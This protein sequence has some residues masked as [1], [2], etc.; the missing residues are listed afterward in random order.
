MLDVGTAEEHYAPLIPNRSFDEIRKSDPN[1]HRYLLGDQH[2]GIPLGEIRVGAQLTPPRQ[3]LAGAPPAHFPTQAFGFNAMQSPALGGLAAGWGASAPPLSDADMAGWPIA[4]AELQSHYEAV[5]QRIG[6]SGATNDALEPFHRGIE[7]LQP[8]PP[9]DANA[10][11]LL[12]AYAPQREAFRAAGFF[13]GA[14]R[15]AMCTQALPGRGATALHDMDF[16]SDAD[17]AVYRPR[18]TIDELRKHSNFKYEAGVVVRTF[19]NAEDGSVRVSGRKLPEGR[20]IEFAAERLILAAGTLNTS[21]IVLSS[22]QKWNLSIPILSNPYVYFPCLMWKRIGAPTGEARHS[23]TQ[24]AAYFVSDNAFGRA[25]QAQ[26]YSY[27]SLLNFKLVKESPGGVSASTQIMR[28]L[29]PYFIIVGIHHEDRPTEA[30]RLQVLKADQHALEQLTIHYARS[31][32]EASEQRRAEHQMMGCFRR[33]GAV[34]IK[35]IDP[36]PGSSIHYGGSLPMSNDEKQLTT[37]P[38]GSLRGARNVF[39]ADGSVLPHLPAKGL[40]FTLMAN[41]DRIGCGVLKGL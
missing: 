8:A 14:P 29:H 38:D 19:A 31:A 34:P 30:K 5:A 25:A 26:V 36:G 17:R 4:R 22:Y 37:R 11:A 16:W 20:T 40:T 9:Q 21:R 24:L 13:L 18:Y 39:I 35:R 12:A 1:Q 28:L 41:A 3:Y 6:I 33:L 10:Q 2:E 27:R 32:Q 23:L 15:L 7:N